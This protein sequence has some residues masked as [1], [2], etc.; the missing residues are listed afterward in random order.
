MT[1]VESVSQG[2]FSS[3]ELVVAS[4]PLLGISL[5]IS[6]PFL[7]LVPLVPVRWVCYCCCCRRVWVGVVGMGRNGF[8]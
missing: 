3:Y 6:F 4:L 1:G 5:I 7:A 2:I 8:E